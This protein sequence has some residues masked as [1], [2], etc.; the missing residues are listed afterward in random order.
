MSTET[1][2]SSETSASGLPMPE[3]GADSGCVCARR[4]GDRVVCVERPVVPVA[5]LASCIVVCG[6]II[7]YLVSSTSHSWRQFVAELMGSGGVVF[8]AISAIPAFFLVY[9]A[10]HSRR[11]VMD[12][13]AGT[14]TYTI[15][16]WRQP[17]TIRVP[18]SRVRLVIYECVGRFVR[19]RELMM[20][21]WLP[22]KRSVTLWISPSKQAM[23][24]RI[25][26]WRDVLPAQIWIS[27]TRPLASERGAAWRLV[28]H[29]DYRLYGKIRGMAAC[30]ACRYDLSGLAAD[31]V[32]PECGE[33]RVRKPIGLVDHLE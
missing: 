14:L 26:A 24:K 16:G 33:P 23:D 31:A 8:L 25:S 3:L 6:L 17:V 12:K 20:V 18:L 22:G 19:P 11:V 28:R 5:C 2:G 9:F 30:H 10:G 21:A 32:C 13:A 27:P 4:R 1:N 15:D 29:S 7:A